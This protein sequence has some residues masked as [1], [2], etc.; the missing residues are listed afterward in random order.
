[1]S[2]ARSRAVRSTAQ[3]TRQNIPHFLF[4]LFAQ[5]HRSQRVHIKKREVLLNK[6]T[7]LHNRL[8]SCLEQ[9][10]FEVHILKACQAFPSTFFIRS[11]KCIYASAADA[12]PHS[13]QG[14]I[15]DKLPQ[16]DGRPSTAADAARPRPRGS[17]RLFFFAC[18]FKFNEAGIHIGHGVNDK[19]HQAA[20]GEVVLGVQ[21]VV[22]KNLAD[23]ALAV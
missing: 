10:G 14:K 20:V 5:L 17:I 4:A 1:M 11:T 12:C 9:T 19:F 16:C 22:L 23:L 21:V 8:F 15:K 2:S 3:K 6:R 13:R 7:S 18:A